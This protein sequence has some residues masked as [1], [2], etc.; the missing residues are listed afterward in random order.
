[1]NVTG[2]LRLVSSL[3]F[4]SVSV[5]PLHHLYSPLLFLPHL[6]VTVF[7]RVASISSRY[8]LSPSHLLFLLKLQYP[9]SPEHA[10]FFF[11][12]FIIPSLS[13]LL[14]LFSSHLPFYHHSRCPLPPHSY[15]WYIFCK[16]WIIYTIKECTPS[17]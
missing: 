12:L 14:P 3:L 9:I 7:P 4:Y 13:S 1:M 2:S 6:L 8:I 17:L 11:L 15:K 16:L 5:L 10:L